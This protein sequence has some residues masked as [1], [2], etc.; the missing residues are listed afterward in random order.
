M[1][2]MLRPTRLRFAAAAILACAASTFASGGAV[3]PQDAGAAGAWQR[4]QKLRTIA[5]A[6]QT[7]AHPDDE[8]G[9]VLA[10]LS[11]GEG[12]RVALLTLTRGESGDNAIG[13]ELF[14]ALGLIRTEE[15]RRAGDYY[16]IDRQYFTSAIDYG[17]SKRLEEAL[18]KWGR[19]QVLRDIVRVIRLE[20]PLVIISRFQG[21]DRDGHG[22]HQ[23]AGVMTQEACRVAGDPSVFPDQIAEGLRPW[24]PLKVYIG[25]VRERDDW[26]LRFDSGVY[27]PW[28]GASFANFARL[29]LALQ[30]SQNSGRVEP[31]SGAVYTYYKRIASRVAAPDKESGFFDGIDTRLT[32]LFD[33]FG[34]P[35]PPEAGSMLAVIAGEVDQAIAAFRGGDPSASVEPLAR[36]LAATRALLARVRPDTGAAQ[37][38]R[39]KETQFAR[40]IDAALGVEF[41]ADVQNTSASETDRSAPPTAAPTTSASIV[42][43]QHITLS[44]R[45]VSHGAPTVNLQAIRLTGLVDDSASVQATAEPNRPITKTLAITVPPEAPLTRPSFARRSLAENRYT[46]ADAA[47]RDEPFIPPPLRAEAEYSVFGVAVKTAAAV[48]GREPDPPYGSAIRELAVVPAVALTIS[49]RHV[50]VAL[51][52]DATVPAEVDLV[53]NDP[54]GARGVLTLRL[55]PGW[56]A[57]PPSVPFAFRTAGERSRRSFV[58][59]PKGQDAGEYVVEAVARVGAREF[60]EGYDEIRH[61]DLERR[62]L[63]RPA[64]AV[65]RGIDVR[66]RDG[67]R[68]GYV[69]G[70]GDEVPSGIAQ[71]GARV[72]LLDAHALAAG[73]LTGYDAIITGT[74]AYGVRPDLRAANG[75][76]LEY[77]RGGGNL[78]VLYNTPNEFDPMTFAPFPARL[79]PDAEEVSEEDSPVRILAPDRPEFTTPNRI[80]LA[81]FE[82]WIEQRGSKFFSDWDAAYTPLLETHDRNQAPQRGGWLTAQFG[83]GRYTYFAYALHRQLP[84]GVPGA[85]R[86]LANLL[87]LGRRP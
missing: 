13:P 86:I 80:T 78:I 64:T 79:P 50:V 56:T 31:V 46:V 42:A 10:R 43:G 37:A 2:R 18:V 84:Y 73:D 6:L 48:T 23:A 27:S 49:P 76:L 68:V 62:Y 66:L 74:R 51:G 19:D 77:V 87:S 29:G 28:L 4:L 85:Y 7:T 32:A 75:R 67:L 54:A 11:R 41:G 20:R 5:S 17:F 8:Q 59:R 21:T 24:Q 61:R 1:E 22:N 83:R 45:F 81:D 53:N 70:A 26:T 47:R 3:P 39:V 71:L 63:Y 9:G 16:G 60:A 58:I 44:V 57:D 69:M 52:K 14:D 38:L 33:T 12:A 65:V 82:G 30:R 36:G 55:P 15:L 25:G 34:E 35:P 72:D 40:A